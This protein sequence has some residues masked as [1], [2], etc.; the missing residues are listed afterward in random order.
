MS[1]KNSHK[2]LFRFDRLGGFDEIV[3]FVSTRYGGVSGP[4]F[5]SLNVGFTAGDDDSSVRRNRQI[6]AENLGIDVAQMVLSKQQHTDI[7]RV[8]KDDYDG[9]RIIP[10][11]ADAMV[12]DRPGW[13]LSVIVADCVPI[14]M[15]EPEK[16]VVA[17]V[18]AGWRGTVKRILQKTVELM[19]GQYGV[20][21]DKIIAG[22]GPSIGPCCYEVGPEVAS[23]V[24]DSQSG[25]E[26]LLIVGDSDRF[27]LDLWEANRRQLLE[28]GV[29]GDNIE[30][31]G[32]CTSCNHD[33]FYSYRY[34]GGRT[35]RMAAGVMT[36]PQAR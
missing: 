21:A 20:S 29:H 32:L 26:S 3:H 5:E 7:I 30:L 9:G 28:A 36:R 18:H 4:P 22:I 31:S 12:T 27:L 19:I 33:R 6:L 10:E 24:R 15:F 8:I 1:D 25:P 2:I 13:C 23:E 17:A 14:L 16:K 35:G 11:V 34:F